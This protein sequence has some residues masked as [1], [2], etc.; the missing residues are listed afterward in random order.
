MTLSDTL[1]FTQDKRTSIY[2]CAVRLFR[3]TNPHFLSST[4]MYFV[5]VINYRKNKNGLYIGYTADLRKR[6][7]EHKS[8]IDNLIYYEAYKNEDDARDRERQLKKYKSAWG[9]LK[10]RIEKSRI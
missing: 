8:K 7:K 9:Q 4:F 2:V 3:N 6:L 5:Y 10:K 1:E